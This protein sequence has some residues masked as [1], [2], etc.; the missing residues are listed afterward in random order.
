MHVRQDRRTDGWQ[1]EAWKQAAA[2][3][4]AAVD[5]FATEPDEIA[6]ALACCQTCPV[7]EPCYAFAMRGGEAHGVWGGTTEQE[8]RREFRRRGRRQTAA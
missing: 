6:R 1:N 7:R 2:C 4:G 5:F 3:N 8:R